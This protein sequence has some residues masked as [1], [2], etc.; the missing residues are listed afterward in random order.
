MT[1]FT[2]GGVPEHFNLPWHLCIENES[3]QKAGI[4]V[5]WKD[6]SGG[7][8]AMCQALRN[9]EID[10]AIILSEGITYDI[11]QGNTAKLFSWY[12][13]SPLVWGIHTSAQAESNNIADF[14]G[15]KYAISR[16]GSG[17]HL[18]AYVDALNRNWEIKND[19]WEVVNNLDRARE[20]LKKQ[21]ASLFLWEKFTTKPYVD[22]GEFKR[23]GECPT[24]WPCFVVAVRKE[25]LEKHANE[26]GTVIQ[27]VQEEAKSLKNNPKAVALIAERYGLL[28]PDVQEWFNATEWANNFTIDPKI[29]DNIQDTLIQIGK[30]EEKQATDLFIWN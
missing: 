21:K 24:P 12:V 10:I 7:T 19:Q 2:V 28:E 15:E 30:I 14:E 29:I 27:F 13:T 5:N 11:I 20:A 6:F 3:F 9:E 18:M 22:N 26:V 16:F 4:T 17:S 1:T 25:I 8:G 23:I